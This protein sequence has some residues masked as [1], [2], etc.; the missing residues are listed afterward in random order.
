MFPL[1]RLVVSTTHFQLAL[2]FLYHC[3]EFSLSTYINPQPL[4]D[5]GGKCSLLAT[6]TSESPGP[7]AF[8][9]LEFCLLFCAFIQPYFS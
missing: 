9:L 8:Y 6:W 4:H 5:F 7:D 2:S 1:I 3:L